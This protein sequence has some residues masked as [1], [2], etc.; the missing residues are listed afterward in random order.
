MA[1]YHFSAQ[2]ISR[3]S[4][5]GT[6][7]SAVAAAAYRSGEKLYNEKDMSYK[8]YE[9]S[10]LP[11]TYLLY[12]DNVPVWAK[13]RE[14][15]WNEVE[16]FEKQY[17]A[18]LARE[19]NIALPKELSEEEQTKLALE[20]CQQNFVNK[21]MV[22]DVSIHR[23]KENNP[24]F[25]VML[26]MRKIDEEGHFMPKATKVYDL[27]KDGNK[28]LLPSGHYKCHKI[29]T[30][31]WDKKETLNK[32]REN[33]QNLANQYL[34]KNGF[35]ERIDCR[36]YAEQNI[37]LTPQIH[38]GANVH[39]AVLKNK[40]TE[41]GEYNKSVRAYN[42]N[43]I[44]LAEYK[45][46]RER[47]KEQ[48]IYRC[49]TKE[50]KV[51]LTNAARQLKFYVTNESLEQRIK[52]LNKWEKSHFYHSGEYKTFERILKE[53]SIIQDAKE[54]LQKEAARF[55]EK[56]YQGIS[57]L[58][59]EQI[60]LVDRTLS[61][62]RI[63][64]LSEIENAKLELREKEFKEVSKHLLTNGNV[65]WLNAVSQ[66]QREEQKARENSGI[67]I[68]AEKVMK[69]DRAKGQLHIYQD[70]QT[71][72]T[73][74]GRQD[75]RETVT[76]VTENMTVKEAHEQLL[77]YIRGTSD[78]PYIRTYNMDK[79]ERLEQALCVMDKLYDEQIR[80]TYGDTVNVDV[81]T[82]PQKEM[83]LHYEEYYGVPF[84]M[85]H[86]PAPPY[87]T[88]DKEHIITLLIHN[89]KE[90]L[91]QKYPSFQNNGAYLN[92]FVMD[93]LSD[94][95]I[96]DDVKNNIQRYALGEKITPDVS[97]ENPNVHIS[98]HSL[99]SSL[100]LNISRE[101]QRPDAS[102][103]PNRIRKRRKKDLEQN[104]QQKYHGQ[105]LA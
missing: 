3:V 2:V 17:N 86:E 74:I 47:I 78:I 90:Q 8:F 100:L 51:Q 14:L 55:C 11:E 43:V 42:Q 71:N 49:F 88:Q 52:Q 79:V 101:A 25:H 50:E 26:T 58:P 10:V 44:K 99:I 76:K 22:A 1:I 84:R 41:I 82:T 83:V 18:Q 5:K 45:Q 59:E 96:S 70:R 105:N 102:E 73:F 98:A 85:N 61:K 54:V 29:N 57:L 37:I 87:S 46:E 27:D 72:D 103:I 4:S 33:W 56:Y 53:R 68:P 23:D 94:N 67:N 30:T 15:L 34:E 48:Q 7:R 89:E 69:L 16:N 12:P 32:W 81:L 39:H 9:R 35:C 63:L 92:M 65:F 64:S 31:D 36:S 77:G 60:E 104:M 80:Q 95:G 38:E 93:C 40:V 21:G 91:Q 97:R 28:I 6:I 19:I 75:N 24:H 13:D 20:Y 66:I 62:E